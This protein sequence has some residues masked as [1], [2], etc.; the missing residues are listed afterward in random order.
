MV[1]LAR[2]SGAA[3]SILLNLSTG[4]AWPAAPV[5]DIDRLTDRG[6]LGD[7]GDAGSGASDI[8]S[9][10][11]AEVGDALTSEVDGSLLD[12]S[13]T[14]DLNEQFCVQLAEL[15]AGRY[16]ACSGLPRVLRSADWQP[17]AEECVARVPV[18]FEFDGESAERCLSE[19]RSLSCDSDL[20][21]NVTQLDAAGSCSR[22]HKPVAFLA[23]G[24]ACFAAKCAGVCLPCSKVCTQKK[25]IDQVCAGPDCDAGLFC[26]PVYLSSGAISSDAY[27]RPVGTALPGDSCSVTAVCEQATGRCD[28]P[29]GFRC[30]ASVALCSV[31]EMRCRG[32]IADGLG[33]MPAAIGRRVCQSS[34]S[35]CRL[36][37]TSYRC[38][39]RLRFG[40][41]CSEADDEC[42]EGLR[43]VRP[44]AGMPAVCGI[45]RAPGSDCTDDIRSCRSGSICRLE[46]S[47]SERKCR[48]LSPLGGACRDNLGCIAPLR[49]DLQRGVC[50]GDPCG[51]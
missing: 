17:F 6:W 45:G 28:V 34:N 8:G 30:D 21:T 14:V 5:D 16:E 22:V 9:A 24:A 43:C 48:E 12:G 26:A 18:A 1:H 38:L 15:E 32:Y 29:L 40:S 19:R 7:A 11:D 3:F 46:S 37:G 2:A 27:C 47:G 50:A 51:R 36:I 33:C 20:I 44:S 23:A 10:R 41:T 49:C 35:T 25:S 39:P 42:Y 4:C 31:E 13:T